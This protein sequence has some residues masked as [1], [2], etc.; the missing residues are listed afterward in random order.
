[1]S[2]SSHSRD[3]F[4]SQ[5]A[6]DER[7]LGGPLD[8]PTE[9]DLTV[10]EHH[11]DH[12]LVTS[13]E[14]DLVQLESIADNLALI[15]RVSEGMESVSAREHELLNLTTTFALRDSG[16]QVEE[17]VP[18]M[19]SAEG[20]V[21]STEGLKRTIKAVW[22]AIVKALQRLWTYIRD[23]FGSIGGELTRLNLRNVQVM[24]R[25]ESAA[26]RSV[27]NETT[28]LGREI[29][30]LS[31][32]FRA[33]RSAKDVIEGL[34]V[35]KNQAGVLYGKHTTAIETLGSKLKNAIGSFDMDNPE[36]SL[37]YVN[38][39]VKDNLDMRKLGRL[40]GEL[41]EVMDGRW[42]HGTAFRPQ[43]LLANKSII[44]IIPGARQGSES[45]LAEA[46]AI[47]GAQAF[48]TMASPSPHDAR[49]E[50]EV[51]TFPASSVIDICNLVKEISAEI[52][53]YQGR[54][55]TLDKIHGDILSSSKFLQ[56]A[57]DKNRDA[58][59]VTRDHVRSVLKYNTAYSRWATQPMTSFS[60][61]AVTVCR[62]ALIA[63]TK[64]LTNLG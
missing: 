10:Y 61:L 17:T 59:E 9:P 36:K 6:F 49:T 5:E 24:H 18:S 56:G 58:T 3:L 1:M 45:A 2:L 25:A 35:F 22:K 40:N 37:T 21:I 20:L 39:I 52:K 62:A 57:L 26:G 29:N 27:K 4:A 14:D 32:F 7:P 60:S 44:Y 38:G 42:K 63:S 43:A 53:D 11:D 13:V 34:L 50:G 8:H 64:S 33:P 54:Q 55:K 46:E 16:L 23:F 12:Y 19:E 47:R 48:I 41:T 31:T 28:K 15:Q 30:T 51:K